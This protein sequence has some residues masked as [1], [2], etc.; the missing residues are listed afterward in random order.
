[1]SGEAGYVTENKAGGLP[2]YEKFYLGGINSLRGFERYSVSPKDPATGDQIGGTKMWVFTV[3]YQFPIIPKAGLHGV[4]FYD[5]GN[6]YADSDTWD[7]NNMR[8]DAGLGVR[9][10]SP[11]GPLRVEWGVNLSP[12]PGEDTNVFDFALGGTFD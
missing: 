10:Y 2:L 1:V 6:V 3:E 4:V 5:T 12:E 7:I 11:M 9:W 8:S